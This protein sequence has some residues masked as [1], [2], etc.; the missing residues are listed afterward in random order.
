MARTKRSAKL[1]TWNARKSLKPELRHQEPIAPGRYLAY[2]RPKSKAAGSWLA[3][4]HDPETKKEGQV[5]LGTADDF[6][7]ADGGEVLTYAQ[8][9]AKALEWF[10]ICAHRATM[11]A[12]GEV[13][14]TGPLTVAQVMEIYFTDGERRGMKGLKKARS[15][16][17]VHILPTLGELEV[18]KLTRH[19][20]EK[21]L[22]AIA[23]SPA[24]ARTSAKAEKPNLRKVVE[25]EDA[26]R[27][28]K[29]T[30]NRVLTVLKAALNHALAR[31]QV[32]GS[33]E[34][35]REVK[36]YRGTTSA[37][38]RFLDAPEQVRLVNA[39]PPD[40]RRLVQAA[41]FTGARCGELG[42]LR[43]KDF[44]PLAGTL[45][46]LPGK[47]GKDRRVVLTE[48][49]FTWFAEQCA[50]LPAGDL[51]FQR[52]GVKR[53]VTARQEL[54]EPEAWL[55]N[56]QARFMK[57]ACEAAKL[58]RMT[59]HELR[60]T[61]ASGL[62]NAGMPLVFVAAQLGH[63]DTRM[64]EKHYGHLAPNALADA[65]RKLAPRLGIASDPKIETL[66][67]QGV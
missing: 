45:Y 49:A 37:R 57:D 48:E 20:L 53:R 30:A 44:D 43:V 14:P 41:L 32:M 22:E 25:P 12:G 6:T 67:V 55:D 16:A 46:I 66:R 29:D 27:A 26:K 56:D 59:F 18:G 21:W 3:R 10:K 58:S 50:G 47:G 17:Q 4:W 23:T 28:R 35:W 62:V 36:P 42:L 64:V 33:G 1:D 31:R 39:C 40:F 54:H 7:D 38:I 51:L 11:E 65:V 2:R 24:Q 5:R 63:Q 13:L 34:A 15:A 61:Y 19:R 9:Q 8:A 60:H 52:P